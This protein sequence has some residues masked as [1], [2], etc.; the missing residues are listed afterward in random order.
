M[1]ILA[2]D[3]GVEAFGCY[4]GTGYETPRIDALAAGGMRFTQCHSQPLC[5]PSRVKLMTGRSNARNYVA[6]GVLDPSQRTFGHA[7]ADAGYDTAVIGKWQLRGTELYGPPRQDAGAMPE[8]AGF[9]RHCLWQVRTL[10]HRYWRPTLTT[11]GVTAE[12]AAAHYGPDRFAAYAE[13]F[14]RETTERPFL[15]YWP[16][17]LVHSPF[18]AAPR[19]GAPPPDAED[20]GPEHFASMVAKLD[21]LVGAIADILRETGHAENTLLLFTSDNG[22][23][24]KIDSQTAAGTVSGGKG[25]TTD[26][27]THVPF[28]AYWP[29][30]IEAGSECDQLIDFADVLPTLLEVS[31]ADWPDEIALD[32]ESLVPLLRGGPVDAGRVRA[33]HY[34]PRPL[35]RPEETAIRF[36]RSA[37]Y[38]LYDDGRLFDMREDPDEQAPLPTAEDSALRDVHTR[39]RRALDAMPS[40]DPALRQFR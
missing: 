18:V 1:L 13:Q 29:G 38:K 15:L 17:A 26:R 3:V 20:R 12:L 23:H 32:G 24:R 14:I 19:D 28:I 21:A 5:T 16:M 39:L 9:A 34:W 10:G 31:G 40:P 11:D 37:R 4:G 6:F 36:A 8:D 22:T 7:L 30:V 27:G 25:S 35:S 2:D 33:F